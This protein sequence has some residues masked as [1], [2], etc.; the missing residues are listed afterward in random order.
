[1][2]GSPTSWSDIA[3][4]G[5]LNKRTS[6]T[7][8][9]KALALAL[10]GARTLIEALRASLTKAGKD[11]EP[12][13][14]IF[15]GEHGG[16]SFGGRE[17]ELYRQC[18]GMLIDL[19]GANLD[20]RILSSGAI[21]KL[22]RDAI[23]RVLRPGRGGLDLPRSA[24]ERRL[25]AELLMLRRE[26]LRPPQTWEVHVCVYGFAKHILPFTFGDIKFSVGSSETGE[27]IASGIPQFTPRR[28]IAKQKAQTID[29]TR[30]KLR[31]AVATAFSEDAIATAIVTAADSQAA[32]HIGVEAVRRVVD[33][34]NYFSSL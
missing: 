20:R 6:K 19:H 27:H 28:R 14:Y 17:G 2:W 7:K 29:E 1:M 22:L 9:K 26:L 3:I 15:V 30:R 21:E 11:D 8:D 5:S 13:E 16:L 34:I 25:T 23:M 24:F 4:G 31:V 12:R 33:I 10:K 18:L 32:K